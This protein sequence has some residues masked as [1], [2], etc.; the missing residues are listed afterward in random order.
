MTVLEARLRHAEQTSPGVIPS[1]AIAEPRDL[2]PKTLVWHQAIQQ[3]ESVVKKQWYVYI[4]TNNSS[5]LYVG[6]TNDLERRV[7]E[8]KSK[9]VPGFTC[10]YNL[11][12]LVYYEVFGRPIHAIERE[13]Q[14][15][16]WR[17][18]KKVALVRSENPQWLDRA[19]D[20][21]DDD[22]GKQVP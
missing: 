16:R 11:T 22:D 21:F 15:K 10:R 13:K 4:M 1:D 18:E 19:T 17:R 14:I 2:S 5:T 3:E 12:Q 9:L 7:H 20:W 6:M 8:H